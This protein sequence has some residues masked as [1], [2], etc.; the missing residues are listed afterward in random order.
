MGAHATAR[1]R[2]RAAPLPVLLLLLLP[3]LLSAAAPAR[4]DH[5]SEEDCLADEALATATLSTFVSRIF[6]CE[7]PEGDSNYNSFEYVCTDSCKAGIAA[8]ADAAHGC[9]QVPSFGDKVFANIRL[10][11]DAGTPARGPGRR[12]AAGAPPVDRPR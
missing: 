9:L 8:T 2:T 4:A 10:L 12:R 1:P 3:L 6:V 5:P 11:A 7:L